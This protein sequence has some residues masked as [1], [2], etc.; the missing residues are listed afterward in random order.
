MIKVTIS[1]GM[2][3][4]SDNGK[5]MT[6]DIL[7]NNYWTAG[8]SSKNTE[9]AQ[10]AGVIG[11]FGIG[12]LA[13]FGICSK[14]EIS[15]RFYDSDVRLNSVAYRNKLSGDEISLDAVDDN[16][17]NYGTIVK[18]TLLDPN[19]VTKEQAEEYLRQ[20]VRYVDIPIYINGDLLSQEKF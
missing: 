9:E 7:K 13:N 11:H 17:D 5:G 8:N 4:I 16:S 18:V 12:A 3:A 1:D 10:Q 2:I 6:K 20:Y 14:L 15:T 19:S